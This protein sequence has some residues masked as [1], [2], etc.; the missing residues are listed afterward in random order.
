[1]GIQIVS[2]RRNELWRKYSLKISGFDDINQK[3]VIY[4]KNS[5]NHDIF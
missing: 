5:R 3:F 1:M 2:E 4:F